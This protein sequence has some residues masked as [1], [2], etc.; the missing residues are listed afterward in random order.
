MSRL[1]NK[2]AIVTGAGT[3]IGRSCAEVFAKEGA[4][5]VCAGRTK[6]TLEETL[7]AVEGAGGKGLVVPT[8]VAKEEDC[9]NLVEATVAK[10]GRVDVLVSA[11]GVGWSWGE[12][13]PGSMNPTHTT[14]LDKW[15]E[16][17]DIN[18]TSV[19]LM[20]KHVLPHMMEAKKGSIINVASVVGMRG[21]TDS[22]TY[23]A[24]KG[25]IL[26]LTR[27]AAIT[28]GQYGIR[29]NSMAPGFVDTAMIAPVMPMF[30]EPNHPI[31][32]PLGRAGKPIDIAYG[33]LYL[34]SDEASYTSGTALVIDGALLARV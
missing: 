12:K 14:P 17:I 29:V 25:A 8:D 18:L 27:S 26:N 1:E 4:T 2:I 30:D 16:V 21:L 32:P 22:H 31:I 34:A 23:T 11:A 20:M 10:Y 19:F 24:T 15:H 7:S 13:S 5:V 6:G 33:C 3:G 28:Y 9:K